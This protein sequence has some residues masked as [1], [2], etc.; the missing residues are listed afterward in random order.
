MQRNNL[1]VDGKAGSKT[2]AKMYSNSAVPAQAPY[3]YET[4]RKGS[5]GET[6]ISLQQVL[7]SLGY[8][9]EK[10][11]TYDDATVTAVKNFQR[12]NGLSVD[13]VAGPSTQEKLFGDTAVAYPGP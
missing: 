6:V 13:G 2:L 3:A 8:L 12:Y 5:T 11:G 7:K 4:L 9:S 10:T 1:T